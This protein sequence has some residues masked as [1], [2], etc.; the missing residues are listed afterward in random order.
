MSQD[1]ET[2]TRGENGHKAGDPT[3]WV[4]VLSVA[5]LF[6]T[7][8]HALEDFALGEPQARGIPAPAIATVLSVLFS[9]QAM[10]L[11]WL[12]QKHARGLWAHV[13]LG[14]V[15]PV[16]SGFAQLPEIFGDA[17]YRSG[18]VSVAYVFGIILVG[19]SLLVASSLALR[20]RARA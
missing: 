6:F 5:L 19:A 4:V 3:R 2:T 18:A 11:Y 16:A 17:P 14:V 12:G 1:L 7:L 8:P 15:W 9:A 13:V 10:G 20:S